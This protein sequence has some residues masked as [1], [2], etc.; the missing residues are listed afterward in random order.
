MASL[1]TTSSKGCDA[2]D[3]RY[4]PKKCPCGKRAAIQ[5]VE[6]E[7][8][9]KG[10]LY[11][12]YDSEPRGCD[13]W[14]WCKPVRIINVGDEKVK[15]SPMVEERLRVEESPRVVHEDPHLMARLVMVEANVE[16]FKTMMKWIWWTSA[17]CVLCT[18]LFIMK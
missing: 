16:A 8:S 17:L 10:K 6:S 2:L 3:L 9:S 11:Y 14:A 15:E 18:I 5:V 4:V 12:V 1:S 13:T 7:K